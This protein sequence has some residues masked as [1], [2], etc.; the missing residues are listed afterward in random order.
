MD[1]GDVIEDHN[2]KGGSFRQYNKFLHRALPKGATT[3]DIETVLYH[4]DPNAIQDMP[5]FVSVNRYHVKSVY[6]Y[7]AILP[8]PPNLAISQLARRVQCPM[9]EY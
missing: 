8:F 1:T 6:I 9:K 5:V 7:A 3:T 2:I 4:S